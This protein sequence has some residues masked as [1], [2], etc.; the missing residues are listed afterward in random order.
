MPVIIFYGPKM[1]KEQKETLV[2]EFA[3]AAGKI[4]NLA[5][6]K[7]ITLINE[8][9]AENVGTGTELLINTRKGE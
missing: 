2:K 9:E 6:E 1:T 7:F 8:I 4:T 3:S 5:P